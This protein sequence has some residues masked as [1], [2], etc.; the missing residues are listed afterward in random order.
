MLVGRAVAATDAAIKYNVLASHWIVTDYENNEEI[1]GGVISTKWD[2]KMIPVGKAADLLEL[3]LQIMKN[4]KHLLSGEIKV[5]NDNKKIIL[6]LD[7]EVNKE[8]D[9]TQEAGALVERIH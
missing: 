4:T 2:D 8:S 3:I 9:C 7:R 5:Y 1:N 6:A